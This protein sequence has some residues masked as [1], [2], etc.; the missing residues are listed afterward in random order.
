MKRLQQGNEASTLRDSNANKVLRSNVPKKDRL[1]ETFTSKILCCICGSDRIFCTKSKPYTREKFRISEAQK[2]QTF[3]DQ[4]VAFQ[5]EM[6]VKYS[7]LECVGG[8]FASDI[9][10]HPNCFRKRQRSHEK[11]NKGSE[12]FSKVYLVCD[13]IAEHLLPGIVRGFISKN[14]VITQAVSDT[15]PGIGKTF[16]NHEIKHCVVKKFL[17]D[18]A[19]FP[20]IDHKG[21]N[22]V[23]HSELSGPEVS[24]K[25]HQMKL[26][27]DA[28]NVIR[29]VVKNI[30]FNLDNF[31]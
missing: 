15:N 3:F 12:H 23:F 18:V 1:H 19:I 17:N 27:E 9:Y 30:N 25:I 2:A 8:V 24:S 13:Y 5:D 26:I 21:S 7:R 31:L 6:S 20:K 4:N 11:Q 16:Q 22:Y 28:G 10:M 14:S 29:N